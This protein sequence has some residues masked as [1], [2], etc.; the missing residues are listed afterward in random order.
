MNIIVT[1]ANGFIGKHICSFL[2][3]QSHKVFKIVRENKN[4]LENTIELDLTNKNAVL[5]FIEDF[6]KNNK[7]DII[8]NLASKLANV[9]Q[10]ED[11]QLQVLIDNIK[12]TKNIVSLVK[13]LKPQKLINFSSIAV[14]PNIDGDFDEKSQIKMSANAECMYGLSKFC[15]ENIFDYMLKNQD[16]TVSHLRVSQV[17]GDGMRQD[18]ILSIMKQELQEKNTITVFG[19]GQRESNFINVNKLTELLN[20]FINNNIHGIYNVGDEL[21]SYLQLAEKI[22]SKN[23]NNDSIII[24]KIEGSRSKFHLNTDKLTK[25]IDKL[26]IRREV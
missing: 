18:R 22:I 12:I 23:G 16:I 24:K 2:E 3:K 1:G 19:E 6:Q 15:S 4:N 11:E 20:Y 17:Y 5:N 10:N 13:E 9:E 26:K 14:Y 8:I 21:L 7:I 25:T